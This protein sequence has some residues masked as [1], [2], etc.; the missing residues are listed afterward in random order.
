MNDDERFIA[1]FTEIWADPQP[2]RF[3]ELF[4]PDGWLLHPGMSEPLSAHDVVAYITGVKA[5]APDLRLDVSDWAASGNL[6]YVSWTMSASIDGQAISWI[7]ADRC[8]LRGDRAES[9][10]AFFDTH[11]LWVALDPDLARGESLEQAAAQ[12]LAEIS[13]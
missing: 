10:T 12:R 3:P 2:E 4:H 11:P 7:G 1:R 8:A 6:L 13:S 9:I 5:G